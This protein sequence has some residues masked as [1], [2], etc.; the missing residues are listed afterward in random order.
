MSNETDGLSRRKLLGGLGT[1][2]TAGILGGAATSSLLWD[3]EKFGNANDPNVLQAGALDLKVDWEEHYFDWRGD[4]VFVDDPETG[5]DTDERYDVRRIGG[6]EDLEPGEV[7]LPPNYPLIAVPE[8]QFAEVWEDSIV[9]ESDLTDQP[10]PVITL[11][12]VKP[13]D[14]GEVTFSYH[15]FDNPGFVSFCGEVHEDSDNGVNEPEDKVNG[16][17]PDGSDGTEGGD[18]GDYVQAKVFVDDNCDNIHQEEGEIEVMFV[19]DV[20]ESMES[21]FPGTPDVDGDSGDSAAGGTALEAV[22]AHMGDHPGIGSDVNVLS[23]IA[24]CGGDGVEV[25]SVS[26]ADRVNHADNLDD[27]DGD[28]GPGGSSGFDADGPANLDKALGPTTDPDYAELKNLYGPG[29]DFSPDFQTD[30]PDTNYEAER[31]YVE[32]GGST[33]PDGLLRGFRALLPDGF[34]TSS[35]FGTVEGID[36][37]GNADFPS[38]VQKLIVVFTDGRPGEADPGFG[39]MVSDAAEAE[40]IGVLPVIVNDSPAPNDVDFANALATTG[41]SPEIATNYSELGTAMGGLVDLICDAASADGEEIL[42]GPAPINEVI[43]EFE[44]CLL[45]EPSTEAT[46][47]QFGGLC[48]EPS[49]T[50][51]IALEWWLPYDLPD[52]NDN[53]IQTDR[54]EFQVSF[55]AVQCRHNVDEEGG[56]IQTLPE[57]DAE[58]NAQH[59]DDEDAEA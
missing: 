8:E 20:S 40:G 35:G 48:H 45:L 23:E 27:G 26:C 46:S 56:P 11:E 33:V 39:E 38:E 24:A 44:E 13:G 53:I 17:D 43:S 57:A 50:N 4:E 25:G 31:P 10:D 59:Y 2:G 12:D 34:S 28:D 21:N 42:V 14:F 5:E 1:I 6:V 7:G 55:E 18:L 16:H 37:S 52:V 29:T 22:K 30:D 19:T 47:E 9:E 36:P 15:V 58:N 3:E 41:I 49:V 51:C 54:L 32:D